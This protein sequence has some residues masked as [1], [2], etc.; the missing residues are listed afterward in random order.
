MLA[1]RRCRPREIDA[2]LNLLSKL[3][4]FSVLSARGVHGNHEGGL[5]QI[6]YKAAGC[7][8]LAFGVTAVPI[9]STTSYIPEQRI[10]VAQ[11]DHSLMQIA[12]AMRNH[13]WTSARR[14]SLLL[15]RQDVKH[16]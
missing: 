2:V 10:Q 5:E 8:E 14:A 7:P 6:S 4:P 13:L 9:L 12:D 11:M 16:T 3:K 15:M 1:T